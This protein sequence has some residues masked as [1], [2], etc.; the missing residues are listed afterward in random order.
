MMQNLPM[1]IEGALKLTIVNRV[2]VSLLILIRN[3]FTV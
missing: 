1:D 3:S 2:L